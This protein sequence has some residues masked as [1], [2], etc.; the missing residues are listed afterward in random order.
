MNESYLNLYVYSPC[1]IYQLVNKV[2][3]SLEHQ[4]IVIRLNGFVQHNDRL[5]MK[6]IARQV[7]IQHSVMQHIFSVV[8]DEDEMGRDFVRTTRSHVDLAILLIPS[9]GHQ[10]GFLSNLVKVFPS[11][12][13]R[14]L[15]LTGESYAGT[16]IVRV[17]P[18]LC[19]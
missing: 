10:M 12:K 7:S 3:N 16:Y 14:P 9:R 2:I 17:S 6:E 11:L 18:I 5:A 15:Y 19:A 4:P 1:N 8:H 13:T